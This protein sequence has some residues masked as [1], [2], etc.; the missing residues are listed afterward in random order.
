LILIL[1]LAKSLRTPSTQIK[2][3][4]TDI[5]YYLQLLPESSKKEELISVFNN[6]N[7]DKFQNS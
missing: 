6:Y 3:I 2:N 5:Q 4:I 1:E 7:K